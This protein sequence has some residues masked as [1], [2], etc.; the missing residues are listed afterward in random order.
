MARID[1]V[2]TGDVRDFAETIASQAPVALALY[3]PIKGAPGLSDLQARR[4]A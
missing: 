2:T 4:V 3:G 1:S